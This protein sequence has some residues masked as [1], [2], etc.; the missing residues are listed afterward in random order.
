MID[1]VESLLAGFDA[2]QTPRQAREQAEE[3]R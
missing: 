1:R 2:D 3:R